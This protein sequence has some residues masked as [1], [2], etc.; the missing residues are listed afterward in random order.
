MKNKP[1]Y[2]SIEMD[3]LI[4]NHNLRP[5]NIVS[6][7]FKNMR[8]DIRGLNGRKASLFCIKK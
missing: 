4:V 6:Q 5:S 8:V 3:A 7:S 1:D 2:E